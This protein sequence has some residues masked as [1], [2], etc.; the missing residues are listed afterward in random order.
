[1]FKTYKYKLYPKDIGQLEHILILQK[2]LYNAALQERIDA[3]RKNNISI[4]KFDQFKSL[5]I[6]RNDDEA[7]RNI[8]LRISRGTLQRLDEAF[9]SFFRRV[10]RGQTPGFPRFKKEMKS[11]QFDEFIGVTLEGSKLCIKGINPIRVNLH[12]SVPGKIKTVT[13]KKDTCGDWWVFFV[14]EIKVKHLAKTGK[15]IGIDSGLIHL[16]VTSDGEFIENKR[17]KV[18][19]SKEMRRKQRRLARAEKY[20]QN[21]TRK[22]QDVA[23]VHRKITNERHTHNHQVSAYL[24]REYD[25]I[26]AEKLNLKGLSKTFLAGSFGD[27]GIGQLHAMITYKAESAGKLFAQVDPKYTSQTCSNCG[28]RQKMPLSNRTYICGLCSFEID[29]DVNAARNILNKGAVPLGTP[30]PICFTSLVIAD[31]KVTGCVYIKKSLIQVISR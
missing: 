23:R 4:S 18:K 9:Q 8:P 2:N 27:A 30:K 6:I 16:V 1:M 26:Y 31:E 10:K 3:Y 20:S 12:R 5:T 15:V 21:R 25:V 29:R 7:F 22:K 11:I 28:H 13:I 14:S 24:V 19:H 17:A